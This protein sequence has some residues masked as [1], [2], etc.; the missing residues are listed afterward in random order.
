MIARMR[1][2][3]PSKERVASRP[4]KFVLPSPAA[5]LWKAV[6]GASELRSQSV[7]EEEKERSCGGGGGGEKLWRAKGK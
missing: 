5:A 3:K 2:L 4:A 1:F 6:K 7:E